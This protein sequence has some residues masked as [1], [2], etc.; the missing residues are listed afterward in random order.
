MRN[1]LISILFL[2]FS[3]TSMANEE[4][5]INSQISELYNQFNIEMGK[6]QASEMPI[7]VLEKQYYR[8]GKKYLKTC[9]AEFNNHSSC[10]IFTVPFDAW[11]FIGGGVR[12]CKVI[13]CFKDY[14]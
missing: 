5:A 11:Y 12:G 3:S 9:K 8:V 7:F 14:F 2:S 4:Q 13:T 6:F 1:L 10:A